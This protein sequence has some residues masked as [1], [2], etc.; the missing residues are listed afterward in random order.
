MTETMSFYLTFLLTAS[1][2]VGDPTGPQ[3]FIRFVI[4]ELRLKEDVFS[5]NEHWRPQHLHCP[6][7]A[8][9]YDIYGRMEDL[10]EDTAAVLIRS[11]N[12]D[13]FKGAGSG[14]LGDLRVNGHSLMGQKTTNWFWRNV[15]EDLRWEI[16]KLFQKDFDL[17]GY[18]ISELSAV[19]LEL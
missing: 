9:D 18:A 12:K 7:C 8:F 13:F 2:P 19:H 11:G 15:A 6:F 1:A 14:S 4:D 10:E 3:T 5:V 16:R 17:F